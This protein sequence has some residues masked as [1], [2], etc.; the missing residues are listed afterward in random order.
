MKRNY[1][2]LKAAILSFTLLFG[3]E[4]ALIVLFGD[5]QYC[6]WHNSVLGNI[7]AWSIRA[8][9]FVIS[10][11]VLSSLFQPAYKTLRDRMIEKQERK[12]NKTTVT[13]QLTLDTYYLKQ[14]R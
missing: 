4:Y 1:A 6:F 14:A 10:S 5:Y 11:S 3:L 8:I 9:L 7:L 2:F 13:E 12:S